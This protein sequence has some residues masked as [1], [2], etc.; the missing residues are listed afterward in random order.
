MKVIS[1]V[2]SNNDRDYH[3]LVRNLE[4]SVKKLGYDFKCY[5]IEDDPM[6]RF[7]TK[8]NYFAPCYFKPKVIRKALIELQED[9]LWLDSDCLMV[10]RVDEILDGSD[11]TVTLRRGDVK[12]I[13]D[14]YD[15]YL[16]AGVMA[17]KYNSDVIKFIDSWIDYLPKSRADQD[18]MN[19]LLLNYSDMEKYNEVF[20]AGAVNVK[21]LPCTIYNNFYFDTD[22]K[23]YHIKGHLRPQHYNNITRKVIGGEY[24]ISGWN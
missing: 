14:L 15:G 12:K 10:E 23:I 8:D 20:K 24:V 9:I 1:A 11:V 13:R 3:N 16:N 4:V 17:F 22:A 5:Q 21:I 19:Q 2:F 18:A 7:A 6:S